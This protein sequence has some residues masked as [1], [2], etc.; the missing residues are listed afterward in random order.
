M[1]IFPNPLGVAGADP[2]KFFDK[3]GAPRRKVPRITFPPCCRF[4]WAAGLCNPW[5]CT[6]LMKRSRLPCSNDRLS[7][8]IIKEILCL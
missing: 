3:A 5:S 1:M 4:Q 2:G 6:F 8:F 7:H